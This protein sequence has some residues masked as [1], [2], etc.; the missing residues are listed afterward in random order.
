MECTNAEE[1]IA[2]SLESG[3]L[4][5]GARVHIE[6]C[7]TC[8]AFRD[9]VSRQDADLRAAFQPEIATA[10]AVAERTIAA[11]RREPPLRRELRF[12]PLV[13]AAAAG[14]LVAFIVVPMRAPRIIEKPVEKIVERIVEKP[15]EKI[16]YVNSGQVPEPVKAPM[17]KLELATG[18]V[19]Q[20]RDGSD[21]TAVKI[22]LG[23][24][25]DTFVRTTGK[26][27]F[28]LSDSTVVRLDEKTACFFG[29][30]RKFRIDNGRLYARVVP[31]RTDFVVATENGSVVTAGDSAL[32]VRHVIGQEKK[33]METSTEILCIEG[34]ATAHAGG[35]ESSLAA[36]SIAL[37][38][39]DQLGEPRVHPDP[40]LATRWVH[41]L[42]IRRDKSPELSIRVK[43][44]LS[45]EDLT[46][47][48]PELRNM[49]G[50]CTGP[51]TS[52]AK[53]ESGGCDQ[54]AR[55]EAVKIASD[56]ATLAHLP[57]LV[58]LLEDG[59]GQV[60]LAAAKG[61][62]RLTGDDLGCKPA[63]WTGDAYRNAAD[64][65]KKFGDK[66]AVKKDTVK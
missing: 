38:V 56:L 64:K 17:A 4:D 65:W 9:D 21:W 44:L 12:F 55:R 16:V 34:K 62:E 25:M 43:R 31:G 28:V 47:V 22:G 6:T 54:R 1:L 58:G 27:E 41:D 24:E 36:N 20:S 23:C 57:D 35:R 63:D 60:R 30:F 37:I 5:D 51:I 61:L 66:E 39:D 49:G 14:F 15:V 48:G 19:E 8:R 46:R 7:A 10:A 53:T 26:A 52:W 32:D 40:I 11:I 29:K 59:D 2:A 18:V 33:V 42:L 3:T 45:T 13:M 50:A